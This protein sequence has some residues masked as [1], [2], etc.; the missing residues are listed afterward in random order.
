MIEHGVKTQEAITAPRARP[1]GPGDEPNGVL[2]QRVRRLEDAVASLQDTRQ[3]EERIAERV[4]DR[5]SRSKATHIPR[6]SAPLLVEASRR[7]LPA[8]IGLARSQDTGPRTPASVP[9]I[10][11]LRNPWLLLDLYSELRAIWR[12]FVDPRYRLSWMG[13]VVPLTLFLAI[14][15]SWY[16]LPFASPL[17][18]LSRIVASL[19]VKI[20]DLFLAYL[21]AK[22][23]IRESKRYRETFPELESRSTH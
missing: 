6:E 11:D 7:M 2:E 14:L 9:S 4:T 22:A 10:P 13:R 17:Y 1:V 8:A 23:L 15:G 18:D 20:V 12:M 19:Y 5:M 21:L 3:M 16:W